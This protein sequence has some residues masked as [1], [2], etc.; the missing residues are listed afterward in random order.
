MN[1][2]I[3]QVAIIVPTLQNSNCCFS[4]LFGCY[5]CVTVPPMLIQRMMVVKYLV[6]G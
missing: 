1:N 4:K 3:L 5:S 2:L 6:G